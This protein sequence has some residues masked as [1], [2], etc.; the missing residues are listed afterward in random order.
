M[1]RSYPALIPLYVLFYQVCVN[2]NKNTKFITTAAEQLL[3][4]LN[5]IAL[6]Y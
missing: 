5:T 3:Q 2:G 6:A 4:Y 1:T